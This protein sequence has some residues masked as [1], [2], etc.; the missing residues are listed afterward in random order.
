VVQVHGPGIYITGS[1]NLTSHITLDIG[2]EATIYGVGSHENAQYTVLPPL[3]S[4]GVCRDDGCIKGDN[5]RSTGDIAATN[6]GNSSSSSSSDDSLVWDGYAN[7][8]KGVCVNRLQALVMVA[9]ADG[10][11]IVG[12]GEAGTESRLRYAKS[13][14]TPLAPPCPYHTSCSHIYESCA[15]IY[16]N[17]V[18]TYIRIVCL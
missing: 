12:G 8:N 9:F 17:R 10:A 5:E 13:H 4:Y 16:T 3:V 15:H 1:F 7:V 2:P 18:L 6:K 14:T 11:R